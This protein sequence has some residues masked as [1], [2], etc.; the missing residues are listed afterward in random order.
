MN[1]SVSFLELKKQLIHEP[2]AGKMYERLDIKVK[3]I[4]ITSVKLQ[5]RVMKKKPW[6]LNKYSHIKKASNLQFCGT[7]LYSGLNFVFMQENFKYI[8]IFTFIMQDQEESTSSTD[9]V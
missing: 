8:Y 4:N 5:K 2:G 3:A 6:S 9:A 7:V 1:P